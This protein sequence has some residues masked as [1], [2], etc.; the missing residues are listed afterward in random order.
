MRPVTGSPVEAKAIQILEKLEVD[1]NWVVANLK[2]VVERCMEA[3]EVLDR[4]GKPTGKY[5]FN[6]TARWSCWAKSWACSSTGAR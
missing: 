1:K 4:K 5:T 2:S 6:A 3:E